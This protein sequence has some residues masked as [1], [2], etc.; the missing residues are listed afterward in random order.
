MFGF[1][2]ILQILFIAYACMCKIRKL[3]EFIFQKQGY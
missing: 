2:H 3:K 1:K